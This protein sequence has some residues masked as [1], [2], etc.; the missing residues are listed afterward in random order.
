MSA[1]MGEIFGSIGWFIVVLGIL[2][3]FHEYGHYVVARLCGV[4]VL[5]FSVGFGRALWSRTARDGTEYRVAAIPLGGYVR[6]LDGREADLLPGEER[7]AFDR[8]PVGQRIA[9]VLAG[10]LANLLLCVAMLWV[11]LMVGVPEHALVVD[12]ARGLAADAGFARGDRLVSIDGQPASTWDQAVLPLVLAAIDHRPVVVAVRDADGALR[13]R[14]LD[15]ARLPADFDQTQP[16]QAIGLAPALTQDRPVVGALAQGAAADGALRPGDEILAIEGQ[17]VARF[18]DIRP[19]LQAEA[20]PGKAL[21]IDVRRDGRAQR[22]AVAPRQA[23]VGDAQVWQLG[24]APLPLE[25]VVFRFTAGVAFSEALRRTGEMTRSTFAV[26]GRL[27]SGQASSRHVSGMI[28]IAQAANAEAG[29][30]LGR[31]LAFMA[32]LS[33]T[34]CIMNLLPIPVLDGGHLLY[35]LIE[36]AAG[37]PLSDRVLVAGQYLGL[38]LLAGLVTLAFYNDLTRLFGRLVS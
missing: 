12:D 22:V 19:L 4:R 32:A 34:L 30:G 18:S 16:F 7:V 23:R 17:P 3:T 29:V 25:P 27:L 37:R 9:I 33:L 26:L 8:K 36:L 28:T 14:R 10:P 2:V 6:M 15:L 5:R 13:E 11:A 38:A 1:A 24:I 21:R 20:A 31:L 35:Y